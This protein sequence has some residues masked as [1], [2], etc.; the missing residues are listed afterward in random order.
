[1]AYR[2][3]LKAFGNFNYRVQLNVRNVFDDDEPVPIMKT[4]TGQTVRIATVE[5]RVIVA[6]FGVDF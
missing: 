2:G 3:R 5:P 4:T 6:T 1:M